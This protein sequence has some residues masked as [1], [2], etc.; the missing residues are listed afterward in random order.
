MIL[1]KKVMLI[2]CFLSLVFILAQSAQAS[3]EKLWDGPVGTVVCDP[4]QY[5]TRQDTGDI[6]QY[7]GDQG[8]KKIGGPAKKF[9]GTNDGLFG[10]SPDGQGIWEYTGWQLTTDTAG[11][12]IQIGGQASAIYGGGHV[13][14]ATNPDT[15]D[16]YLYTGTPMRWLK[17]GGPGKNFVVTDS[18]SIVGLSPDSNSIWLYEGPWRQIGGP[19]KEIYSSTGQHGIYATNPETGD[20]YKYDF[21]EKE[22]IRLGGP[23]KMFAADDSGNLYG[24]SNDGSI[25]W[26]YMGVPDDW[27]QIGGPAEEIYAGGSGL[28]ITS[29]VTRKLFHYIP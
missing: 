22:W 6:Y 18:N 28:Y 1:L 12:W 20:I 15:G 23:G 24:L 26:K 9:I 13:L 8:Y 10:L 2:L 21:P 4:G 16:L 29:P 14:L 7:R 17:I 27:E 19:A 11:E 3:W 25:V 5:A